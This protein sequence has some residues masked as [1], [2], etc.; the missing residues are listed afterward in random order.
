[1]WTPE[2]MIEEALSEVGDPGGRKTSRSVLFRM[3]SRIQQQIAREARLFRSTDS[4]ITLVSGTAEYHMPEKRLMQETLVAQGSTV[5]H[6][7]L[8]QAVVEV[9]SDTLD[10]GPYYTFLPATADYPRGRLKITPS[11]YTG[12]LDITGFWIPGELNVGDTSFDLPPGAQDYLYSKFMERMFRHA[13]YA[14][15]DL[16]LYWSNQSR[17]CR[18]TAVGS[19][20]DAIPNTPAVQPFT[21]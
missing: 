8:Q 14:S 6:P 7:A 15:G 16:M 10:A 13:P 11:N 2:Q 21:V 19:V 18:K 1:M 20:Q 4:S 5:F 17:M 9:G 3:L 12:A